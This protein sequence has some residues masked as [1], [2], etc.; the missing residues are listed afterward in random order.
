MMHM[1]KRD[2]LTVSQI[3]ERAPSVYAKHASTKM[4]DSYLFIPTTQVI[5]ALNKTGLVVVEKCN[6]GE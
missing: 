3:K 2:P 1:V 4:S 5:D 6:V